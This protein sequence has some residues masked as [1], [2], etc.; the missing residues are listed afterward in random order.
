MIQS[1]RLVDGGSG[2]PGEGLR[3]FQGEQFDIDSGE[4]IPTVWVSYPLVMTNVAIEHGHWNRGF[5][6]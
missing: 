4:K 1:A 2:G 6:H 3:K 5:S